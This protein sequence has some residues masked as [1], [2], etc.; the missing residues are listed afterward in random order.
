[1]PS[2]YYKIPLQ[3]GALMNREDLAKTSLPESIDQYL[4]LI[5]VTKY[6]ELDA[7]INFGC[8]IWEDDFSLGTNHLNYSEDLR[9]HLTHVIS[10]YEKRLSDVQVSLEISQEVSRPAEETGQDV[11]SNIRTRLDIHIKAVIN[12]TNNPF[13]KT[14]SMYISPFSTL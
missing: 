2:G 3:F 1:M 5:L 13:E 8:K 6:G 11:R 14:Y 9:E 10:K 12:K 4:R 7:D